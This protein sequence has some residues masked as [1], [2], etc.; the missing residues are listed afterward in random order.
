MSSSPTE[1]SAAGHQLSALEALHSTPSRRYLAPDPIPD[2]VLW[3]ILDA[4]IRGPSGGNRPAVGMGRR[5]RPGGQGPRRGLVPGE[6]GDR[7][8][9]ASRADPGRAGIR[10]GDEPAWVP[11]CRAPRPSPRGGP[12]VGLPGV[13]PRGG[14][15]GPAGRVVYLRRRAATLLAARA[16]GVGTSLTTLY[17]GHEDELRDLLGLPADALTMALIPMGYPT[18]GQWAGPKR[19]PVEEVVHWDRWGATHDHTPQDTPSTSG[20]PPE[21]GVQVGVR[22]GDQLDG[23]VVGAGLEVLVEP[24]PDL[25]VVAGD[26]QG[27]DQ[28]VAALARD[29]LGGEAE[30]PQVRGV[31][32]QAQV[33]L[34]DSRPRARARAGSA[35]RTTRCSGA[36]SLPGPRMPRACR[37]CSG[38]T[39]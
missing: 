34:T 32:R 17:G 26:D 37:V 38:V 2:D 24:S 33:R 13:A 23:H 10:V 25:R 5:D 11:R 20:Q 3:T 12:G 39:R 4:A 28:P 1:A 6:L 8:R 21:S 16:Y 35:S 30:P 36:S 19:R 7:L 27:V 29:V 18:R 22:L 14:H 9:P 31:V 15:D